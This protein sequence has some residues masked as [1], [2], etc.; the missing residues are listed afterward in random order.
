VNQAHSE[1]GSAELEIAAPMA[2]ELQRLARWL[3]LT[4]INVTKKGAM[5]RHLRKYL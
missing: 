4:K 2:Q 1:T 5:A 3:G